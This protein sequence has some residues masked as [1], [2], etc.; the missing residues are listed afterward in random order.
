MP[1]PGMPGMPGMRRLFLL[2]DCRP[3]APRG[4]DRSA[5]SR[6][7]QVYRR[8]CGS[9]GGRCS[10]WR[11]NWG[12]WQS[13]CQ[14][15]SR[16]PRC[17]RST[18]PSWP[19]QAR[20]RL[21]SP[22]PPGHACLVLR[23][24][25]SPGPGRALSALLLLGFLGPLGRLLGLLGRLRMSD[26]ARPWH[27]TSNRGLHSLEWCVMVTVTAAMSVNQSVNQEPVTLLTPASAARGDRLFWGRAVQVRAARRFVV[28]GLAH[29]RPR[30]RHPAGALRV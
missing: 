28:A 2:A 17:W 7:E 13:A 9:G 24:P 10:G 15:V 4:R 16:P 12:R 30:G 22:G 1:M 19:W 26:P 18:S 29:G 27:G 6:P 5:R 25:W 20:C 11:F 8:G 21:G 14:H 23:G 3:G